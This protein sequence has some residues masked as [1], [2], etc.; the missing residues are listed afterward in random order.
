MLFLTIL[1]TRTKRVLLCLKR[2]L[3][4]ALAATALLTLLL[5]TAMAVFS[6]TDSIS[7]KPLIMWMLMFFVSAWFA[8]FLHESVK[9]AGAVFHR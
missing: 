3:V 9:Y 7:F 5:V 4:R 6:G 8:L 2:V 1:L